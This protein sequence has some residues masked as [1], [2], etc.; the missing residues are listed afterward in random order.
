MK[1][2]EH[3]QVVKIEKRV[4]ALSMRERMLLC[5]VCLTVLYMLWNTMVYSYVSQTDTEIVKNAE[6]VRQQITA[7]EG[8]VSGITGILGQNALGILLKQQ[9]KLIKENDELQ[10]KIASETKKLVTPKDMIS[11]LK[12]FVVKA[13]GITVTRLESTPTVGLLAL[14][15]D[16]TQPNVSGF[17][18][19]THGLIIEITGNFFEIVA[20]LKTVEQQNLNMF[21]DELKYEVDTYPKAKVTIMVHTLSLDKGWI[22][23]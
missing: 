19:Y 9:E 7:L 18:I 16:A 15:P 8:Q 10:E 4:N 22:G 14:G 1:I 21:W 23:V 13:E 6:M 5:G 11:L 20:F 17:Q 12:G 2:L 3:P